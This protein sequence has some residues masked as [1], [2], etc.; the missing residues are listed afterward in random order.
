MS[1]WMRAE[2]IFEPKMFWLYAAIVP[3]SISD[4]TPLAGMP[5]STTEPLL[6]NMP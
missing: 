3:G 5:T 2:P 6:A 1:T 4:I